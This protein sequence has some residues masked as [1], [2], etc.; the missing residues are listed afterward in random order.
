M[1][2]ILLALLLLIFSNSLFSQ[3]EYH[4]AVD[5]NDTNDGS[6][7]KP[8]KTI[9]AAASIARPG[10]VVTVHEGIYR[11]AVNPPRGGTSPT[12][13]I[14]YQ[15]AAGEK[16]TITGSEQIS[17]W[18]K[19]VDD[20][21][22]VILPNSYFG[23]FNP[24]SDRIRGDW[25][26]PLENHINHTGNVYINGEWIQEAQKLD[27]LIQPEGKEPRW[28]AIVDGDKGKYLLNISWFKPANASK[29][30]AAEPS[31]RYGS[32]PV[33]CSEGGEC[34]GNILIGDYLRFDDVDFGTNAESIEFRAASGN[35]D[36]SLIEIRLGKVDGELLGTCKIN[37]TGGWQKWQNFNTNIKPTSGKQTVFLIFL[38][39]DYKE[40]NTTIYA[41]FPNINPNNANVEISKRETVFYPSKN[42]INYI[43]VRGFILKNASPN[44]APPSS[45]QKAII[46]TNWSKGWIIEN[47]EICYS[48]CTGVSLGKYGD[49]T[50]NTNEKETADP[51]TA[52]VRRALLNGWN[53]DTIGSHT[54]RNNHIHHCEQT[55]IVGSMGCAFSKIYGNEIH[56]IHVLNL[57]NG[58]EMAGIKLH[59]AVDVEIY[60]NHI[61]RCGNL[62]G[63]WLD[64]MA[65][66]AIVT[67]NLF[68][69]N[70]GGTGDVFFEM[71]HGPV[72][73]ANNILLSK[74]K[75]FD[76]NAKGIAFA[77]NLIP[78]RYI[79]VDLDKRKTPF[80]KAHST[81]IAGL[82]DAPSGD[83]RFYNNVFVAPFTMDGVNKSR[84]ECFAS[85]NVYLNGAKPSKYDT[86]SVVQ[87]DFNPEINLTENNGEWFLE[88]NVNK[89]WIKE[90]NQKLVSSALLGKAK[91]PQATYE[92]TD[93]TPLKI[94]T[95][96]FGKKRNKKTPFPGPIEFTKS[97][98]QLLKVWPVKPGRSN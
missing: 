6:I 76:M 26:W 86:D 7:T 64:W 27:E 66:G 11:E 13:R 17:N 9:S 31:L 98:K 39:P 71:L 91:V 37:N 49:G 94:D 89:D 23:N 2:P 36:G 92:N 65:Q 95:D 53:K 81:E 79:Y 42:F 20:T 75:S 32:Q 12:K 74:H 35:T 29:V 24:Y 70:I 57:F 60:N 77:H 68:H 21:W 69:D 72:V 54:V 14:T 16:V 33:K 97:G 50:D 85:G 56:E 84:L 41:R 80:H 78:S 18:V 61:Y 52:C 63:L 51:Y 22:K 62:G 28:Y 93:G 45:E 19:V 5:G 3:S 87:A 47:N 48:K 34:T 90:Q 44:W 59:G 40:G 88:I 4:V 30:L 15:A 43:T 82:F 83:H 25:F 38:H 10:D 1:K 55:G 46:G 8:F 58:A 67:Q 96:Y 73:F